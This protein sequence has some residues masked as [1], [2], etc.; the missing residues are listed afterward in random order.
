MSVITPRDTATR[1][2]RYCRPPRGDLFLFSLSLSL[3]LS[4]ARARAPFFFLFHRG[5]LQTA[6]LY[7]LRNEDDGRK[8]ADGTRIT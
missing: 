3:S 1:Y 8:N 5:S 2:N 7:Y 4:L 6:D